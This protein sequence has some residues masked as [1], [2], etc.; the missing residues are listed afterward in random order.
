MGFDRVRALG[1]AQRIVRGAQAALAV[2]V[3]ACVASAWSHSNTIELWMVGTSAAGFMVFVSVTSLIAAVFF[4][5]ASWREQ[6][7]QKVVG[8]IEAGVSATFV[9]FWLSGSVS[10]LRATSLCSHVKRW[11]A[12]TVFAD[13]YNEELQAL[14]DYCALRSAAVAFGF[15]AWLLWMVSTALAG[16]DMRSGKGSRLTSGA[17]R[18]EPRMCLCVTYYHAH[19]FRRICRWLVQTAAAGPRRST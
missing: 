7:H 18:G 4:L 12:N 9:V 11:T 14:K 17:T 3:L 8:A 1:L 6:L 19:I 2:I 5:A 15:V 10:F 16:L 13:A